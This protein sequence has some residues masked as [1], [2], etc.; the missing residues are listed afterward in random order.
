M[1]SSG[2]SIY[3]QTISGILNGKHHI[4]TGWIVQMP[5]FILQVQARTCWHGRKPLNFTL[6]SLVMY[7]NGNKRMQGWKASN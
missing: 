2:Q 3:T 6:H 5:N 7:L 4:H 1:D